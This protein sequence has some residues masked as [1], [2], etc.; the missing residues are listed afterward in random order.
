MRSLP[1]TLILALEQYSRMETVKDVV[2]GACAGFVDPEIELWLSFKELCHYHQPDVEKLEMRSTIS[3]CLDRL[4]KIRLGALRY[5]DIFGELRMYS[6]FFDNI[7]TCLDLI[8]I[9]RLPWSEM[10]DSE[11]NTCP[12]NEPFIVSINFMKQ[13]FKNEEYINEALLRIG[14]RAQILLDEA[15][16]NFRG[17]TKEVRRAL[18]RAYG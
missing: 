9:S 18:H 10:A 5:E 12:H 8:A 7:L 16:C 13:F 11:T 3:E 14:S 15:L 17:R 6:R 1:G 4:K 2:E